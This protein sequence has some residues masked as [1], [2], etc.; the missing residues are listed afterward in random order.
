MGSGDDEWELNEGIPQFE[1]PFI[2]KYING[3]EA[4]IQEE[5][6]QRHGKPAISSLDR[7]EEIGTNWL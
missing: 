3:R 1:D 5:R 6:K 7:I 4:L 2:Q